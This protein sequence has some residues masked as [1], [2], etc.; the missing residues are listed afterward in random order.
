MDVKEET[1]KEQMW[2]IYVDDQEGRGDFFENRAE[3]GQLQRQ[4]WDI[5]KGQV[6]IDSSLEGELKAAVNMCCAKNLWKASENKETFIRWQKAEAIF[7]HTFSRSSADQIIKMLYKTRLALEQDPSPE[8]RDNWQGAVEVYKQSPKY[9]SERAAENYRQVAQTQW[10]EDPTV[11]KRARWEVANIILEH[12]PMQVF[13]VSR[14]EAKRGAPD[15]ESILVEPRQPAKII[16]KVDLEEKEKEPKSTSQ[17]EETER[18][19]P[20]TAP[21]VETPPVREIS[22]EESK[23]M[24]NAMRGRQER[25]GGK[26]KRQREKESRKQIDFFKAVI[27][28]PKQQKKKK[29][30]KKKG[31]TIE[32]MS[33][34]EF[35]EAEGEKLEKAQK[36]RLARKRYGN[37]LIAVCEVYGNEGFPSVCKAK[38]PK[39]ISN[40]TTKVPQPL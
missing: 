32:H 10:E 5:V 12:A 19:E 26:T 2:R 4:L 1:I 14:R 39:T 15:L 35:L 28:P 3:L 37:A 11:E 40:S 6:T 27:G 24:L 23:A 21:E 13:S 8:T 16:G 20:Q 7:R 17:P 22:P 36:T 33:P 25:R 9:V 30:G 29:K 18:E 34:I 31:P 38:L